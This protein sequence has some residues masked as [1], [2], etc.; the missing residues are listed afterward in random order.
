MDCRILAESN[1]KFLK[2]LPGR[3]S[4]CCVSDAALVIT[5]FSTGTETPEGFFAFHTVPVQQ[6]YVITRFTVQVSSRNKIHSSGQFKKQGIQRCKK[7]VHVL[8]G[9]TWQ[10]GYILKVAREDSHELLWARIC[11]IYVLA[12]IWFSL[13]RHLEDRTW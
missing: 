11:F 13:E 9:S 7:A 2:L 8:T 4:T 1:L 12:G 6:C 5:G 3:L 10:H